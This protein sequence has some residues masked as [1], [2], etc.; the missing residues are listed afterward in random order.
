MIEWAIEADLIDGKRPKQL[1][2]VYEPGC[3]SLSIQHAILRNM[4]KKKK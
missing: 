1:Q 3:A 2:I 4:K